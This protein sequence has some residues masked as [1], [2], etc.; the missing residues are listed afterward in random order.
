MQPDPP[1]HDPR[2]QPHPH[3]RHHRV[4]QQ[5]SRPQRRLPADEQMVRPPRDQKQPAADKR[6]N[7]QKRNGKGNGRK[8]RHPQQPQSQRYLPKGDEHNTQ[9][10][11]QHLL[12]RPQQVPLGFHHRPQPP[13]RQR[14]HNKSRDPGIILQKEDGGKHRKG[15]G[16]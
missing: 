15:Q 7:I 14:P 8:I 13:P 12:H 3:H 9:V 11:K 6:Q 5:Q 10:G 4:K 16:E 2:L 1:A